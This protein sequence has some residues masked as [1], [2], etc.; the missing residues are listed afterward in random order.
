MKQKIKTENKSSKLDFDKKFWNPNLVSLC[1]HRSLNLAQV[2]KTPNSRNYMLKAE[3]HSHQKREKISLIKP[4][5]IEGL[6]ESF[7]IYSKRKITPRNVGCVTKSAKS[8]HIYCEQ[9]SGTLNFKLQS[10]FR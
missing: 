8:R 9:Q 2:E 6:I 7:L 1:S 5:M 4:N 3:L 10:F